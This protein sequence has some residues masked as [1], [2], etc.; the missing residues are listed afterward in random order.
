VNN[1]EDDHNNHALLPCDAHNAKRGIDKE[2]RPSVR[3]FVCPS[4]RRAVKMVAMCTEGRSKRENKTAAQLGSPLE[5][6]ATECPKGE[7]HD[8]GKTS[9][10]RERSSGRP[11]VKVTNK[12]KSRYDTQPVDIGVGKSSGSILSSQET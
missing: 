11:D 2:S 3:L 4:V 8:S 10:V 7:S 9:E 1:H 5:V 6:D 12:K